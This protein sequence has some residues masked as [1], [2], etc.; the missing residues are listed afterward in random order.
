M[1]KTLATF[2]LISILLL[3]FSQKHPIADTS[4]AD[5]IGTWHNAENLFYTA[6]KLAD[7][8]G[9]DEKLL[10]KGDELYA[11]SHT[12]YEKVIATARSVKNDSLVFLA[13]IKNGYIDQYLGNTELSRTYFLLAEKT[14]DKLPNMADSLLFAPFIFTGGVYQTEN[15]FDSALFYYKKAEQIAALYPTILSDSKRLYNR[16][17]MLHYESG[18]FNQ[19]K[20]YFEK[21]IELTSATETSFRTNYKINIA[22]ILIKSGEFEAAKKLYETLLPNSEYE[23][24]IT[25]NLGIISIRTGDYKKAIQYLSKVNYA[26]NPK[27]ID[28]LFNSGEAW[29]ALGEEDSANFYIQKTLAEN[30]KWNG[31]KKTSIH[32]LLLSLQ[33]DQLLNRK[34]YKQGIDLLQQAIVQFHSSF[35]ETD[36]YKNPDQFTSAFT[37]IHLFNT[38]IKKAKAFQQLYAEQKEEKNLIASSETYKSAFKLAGYVERTYN[39]DEARLF[40][41]N[42]KYSAHNLPIDIC[43]QLYDLTGK[44]KY[45]EDAY[46]FDQQ[47]KASILSLSIHE[48]E[49]KSLPNK[50]NSLLQQIASI[51]TNITRL[52]LKANTVTDSAGLVNI[53]TSIRDYEIELDKLQEKVKATPEWQQANIGEQ[54]PSIKSLQ[55][56]LDNKS[57]I[58]SYHLSDNEMFALIIT[59]N[60]LN[61]Y[62]APVDSNF[63]LGIEAFKQALH[64]TA[65]GQ[66]YEGINASR[67]LFSALIKP[68]QPW[69]TQTERLVIIPDDELHYLPFEALQDNNNNYLLQKYSVQ[70]LYS[71]ALFHSEKN[72]SRSSGILS[73]APFASNGYIDSSGSSFGKLSASGDEIK[74]L[75][76]KSLIDTSASKE[77]F[78]KQANHLPVIHLATHASVNNEDANRSFVV[79]Y[80][81]NNDYKLYAGEIYNMR[82][83]STELVILSACETGTGKLIKGEGLMSLSR[84]FAYAGC[85]N[86]IT[87]LWKAE[88]VTTSFITKHLHTYLSKGFTKDKALRH[89]KADLLTSTDINPQ[90]K[91]PN[92]WAHLV[93]V[94]NYEEGPSSSNWVWVAFAIIF[95]AFVYLLMLRKK[96]RRNDRA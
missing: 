68:L 36:T 75:Q 6:E 78:I 77:N 96:P 46:Q 38:L 24:E 17:G 56:K 90:F 35:N 41:N 20:N 4:Y 61:Y 50:T 34:Q 95:F 55:K 47:N 42:I 91:T 13:C 31:T 73:F 86:I 76:G 7:K 22:T 32:G 18:N 26:N 23:N 8:A 62:K 10:S 11:Q 39:S 29:E 87:S 67:Y 72:Y 52:S 66:R 43:I 30:I 70:Y 51:K 93:F 15:Q 81:S 85:K 40:L 28:L 49:I 94:G 83:D 2:L 16:L 63:F 1:L 37:Y 79:F 44:K 53:S 74:D 48:S 5:L 69:L 60:K 89:A 3:C 88:D 64:Q 82:L 54:I 71:T 27:N 14:K 65:G 84:A 59:R 19:A 58:I 21:A 80:P 57:A 33:A 25:H 9:E 92:Y 45:L 12:A